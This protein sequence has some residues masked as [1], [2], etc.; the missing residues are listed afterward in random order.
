M[1]MSYKYS[2]SA[3]YP[4]FSLEFGVIAEYFFGGIP[5]RDDDGWLK[6]TFPANIDF[7]LEE[8]FNHR[9]EQR[10]YLETLAIWEEIKKYPEIKDWSPQIWH[11]LEKSI[12][13]GD[14]WDICQ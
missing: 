11:E 5:Y 1:G 7:Y 14:G 10:T 8:W 6:Y 3:S 2:G 9:Y 4:R 12:A 13:L